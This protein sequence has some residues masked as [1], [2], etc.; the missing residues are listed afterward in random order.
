MSDST[1]QVIFV[2]GNN[3]AQQNFT[4]SSNTVRNSGSQ[5]IFIQA[6]GMS[7][8]QLSLNDNTVTNSTLDG[9]FIQADA[10]LVLADVE[11]NILQNNQGLGFNGIMNSDRDFCLAL[12]GNESDRDFQVQRNNG[13]FA[14]ANRDNLQT[15]NNNVPV[16]FV[17]DINAF[18][19]VI[20]CP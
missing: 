20:V 13:T 3:N 8:Q 10:N 4:V 11:F 9:I 15:A 18:T 7:E 1:D 14:I 17:P 12:N 16:N 2:Q 6:N 5:G 19:N